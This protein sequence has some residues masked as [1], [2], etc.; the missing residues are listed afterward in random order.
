MAGLLLFA[1]AGAGIAGAVWSRRRRQKLESQLM[2]LRL[3]KEELSAELTTTQTRLDA[4]ANVIA[5]VLILD[6]LEVITGLTPHHARLL[7]AAGILTYND[8]AKLSTDEIT[9]L[10]AEAGGARMDVTRWVIQARQLAET[11]GTLPT[12]Y[13]G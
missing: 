7:N 9:L 5:G 4:T 2:L 10:T 12:W 1:T 11:S 6:R 8:L 13:G 3:E